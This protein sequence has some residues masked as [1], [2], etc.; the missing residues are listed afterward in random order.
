MPSKGGGRKAREDP[1]SSDEDT[2]SGS[3]VEQAALADATNKKGKGAAAKGGAKAAA[4][5]AAAADKKKK[6]KKQQQ[7]GKKGGKT[8]SNA[9][10]R[11][12]GRSSVGSSSGSGSGSDSADGSSGG[13]EAPDDAGGR[14]AG[15]RRRGA[16][17]AKQAAGVKEEHD[18]YTLHIDA[19]DIDEEMGA[20]APLDLKEQRAWLRSTFCDG[21]HTTEPLPLDDE[22]L[23]DGERLV[24]RVGGRPVGQADQCYVES[25]TTGHFRRVTRGRGPL[26]AG[27]AHV[28]WAAGTSKLAAEAARSSLTQS[29]SVAA[30]M[31]RLMGVLS[32]ALVTMFLTAQGI[33]AGVSVSHL[34]S[35]ANF[36]GMPYADFLKEYAT[37]ANGQRRLFYILTTIS[38]VAAI[39]KFLRER[40][41]GDKA[42]WRARPKRQRLQVL[43]SIGLFLAAHV[44]TLLM[45]PVDAAMYYRCCGAE[46]APEADWHLSYFSERPS[47]EN[48]VKGW[49][50]LSFLRA[51]CCAA[52]WLLACLDYH[53]QMSYG[54][55]AR[56]EVD[57][58][59]SA[60]DKVDEK[61]HWMRGQKLHL[62]SREE[63]DEHLVMHKAA[64]D[65]TQRMLDYRLRNMPQPRNASAGLGGGGGG[66]AQTPGGGGGGG[67]MGFAP[68]G[69]SR[70]GSPVNAAAAAAAATAALQKGGG[71]GGAAAA[72]AGN[73]AAASAVVAASPQMAEA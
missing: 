18:E 6:T 29:L 17:R 47:N 38:L 58:M 45:A 42:A 26:S 1:T 8:P 9:A 4:A 61:L 25:L 50:L 28:G 59:R 44:L 24:R 63:L 65:E 2:T 22:V 69:Y 30:S 11:N 12:G 21:T 20:I 55:K 35:L 39:E 36:R 67:S 56:D 32:P 53:Q 72:A 13:E 19:A 40:A 3:E 46:N 52:A 7:P 49:F 60:R 71:D 23:Y 62:L 33:L 10:A 34:V 70:P 15:A 43:A 5:A 41:G 54:K 66:G 31:E 48:R 73:V 16:R 51:F 27:S 14:K 68:P 64:L 57:T 37:S